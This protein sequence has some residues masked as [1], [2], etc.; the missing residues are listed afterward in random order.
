[1]ASSSGDGGGHGLLDFAAFDRLRN[2]LGS[3]VRQTVTGGNNETMGDAVNNT[4][5]LIP[6]ELSAPNT[7][8]YGGDTEILAKALQQQQPRKQ[9]MSIGGGDDDD[10]DEDEDEYTAGSP[11]TPQ[12]QLEAGADDLEYAGGGDYEAD[13]ED[14]DEVDEHVAAQRARQRVQSPTK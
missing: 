3:I 4:G 1:L 12:K 10:E 14:E 6:G 5:L 2:K 9:I 8:T 11:S 7:P 13:E